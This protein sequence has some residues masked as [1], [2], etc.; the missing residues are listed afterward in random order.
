M[1]TSPL[2]GG[3]IPPSGPGLNQANPLQFS[4]ERIALAN[5]C[6]SRALDGLAVERSEQARWHY[7]ADQLAR[8]QSFVHDVMTVAVAAQLDEADDLDATPLEPETSPTT[9]PMPPTSR[10]PYERGA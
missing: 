7:V 6:L 5:E 10:G 3:G 1:S 4:R 8:T 2:P 9:L